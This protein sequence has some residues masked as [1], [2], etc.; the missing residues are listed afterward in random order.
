MF[1]R[2]PR[3]LFATEPFCKYYVL[4]TPAFFTP[5]SAF[6]GREAGSFRHELSFCG[7]SSPSRHF[8]NI[9][10]IYTR[11]F[12]HRAKSEVFPILPKRGEMDNSQLFTFTFKFFIQRM[13]SLGLRIFS[14]SLSPLLLLFLHFR[15]VIFWRS[16]LRWCHLSPVVWLL[17]QTADQSRCS[18]VF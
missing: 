6:R 11:V 13:I 4:N 5:Q 1:C 15:I 10:R 7:A 9:V 8:T 3:F 2:H 16:G 18:S 14:I 12:Y 17:L